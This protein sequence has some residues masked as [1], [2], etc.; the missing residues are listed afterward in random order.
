MTKFLLPQAAV[1]LQQKKEPLERSET[2][3]SNFRAVLRLPLRL[4]DKGT[5]GIIVIFF[6]F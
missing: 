1:K 4:R 2:S 6:W 5:N 3:G